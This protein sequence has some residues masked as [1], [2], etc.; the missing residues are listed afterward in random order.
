M[1]YYY[2]NNTK[3]QTTQKISPYSSYEFFGESNLEL[4]GYLFT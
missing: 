4:D 1:C 2:R 3:I